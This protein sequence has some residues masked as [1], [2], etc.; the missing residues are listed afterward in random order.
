MQDPEPHK[1]ALAIGMEHRG[2]S[3]ALVVDEVGDVISLDPSAQIP[4]LPHLDLQRAKLT[5][6]VYRLEKG[7]LPILEMNFVFAF[8]KRVGNRVVDKPC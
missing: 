7:I 4:M 1:S 6:A 2:E 5:Q 3:F 8:S